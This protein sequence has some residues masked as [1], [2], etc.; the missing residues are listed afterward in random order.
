MGRSGSGRRR[1]FA[2]ET[3]DCRA[4]DVR[5]LERCGMLSLRY[6][7]DWAWWRGSERTGDINIRPEDHQ[8]VLTYRH[9]SVGQHWETEEYAVRLERTACQFGGERAWFRCPASGC[10]K[11]V[12]I[13][14]GGEIFACRMCHRLTYPSQNRTPRERAGDRLEALRR[15]LLGGESDGSIFD[16]VPP[17]PKGMHRRTYARLARMYERGRQ[18]SFVSLAA[19]LRVPLG[20]E[21]AE[22]AFDGQSSL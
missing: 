12:A 18:L 10:G 2:L 16:P 11:R 21:F 1:T 4:L 19:H 14:Y 6:T 20:P 22:A 8:V 17:R 9:R 5:Q 3:R 7:V 13:L 15:R